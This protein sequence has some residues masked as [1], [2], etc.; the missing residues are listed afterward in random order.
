MVGASV[1]W[2]LDWVMYVS[3]TLQSEL[4]QSKFP[5]KKGDCE[6]HIRNLA[7]NIAKGGTIYNVCLPLRKSDSDLRCRYCAFRKTH[8]SHLFLFLHHPNIRL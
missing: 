6:N 2:L 1:F 3:A 7:N 4:K 8:V 5:F